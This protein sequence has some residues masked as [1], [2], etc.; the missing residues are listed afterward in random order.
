MF[1]VRSISS[2]PNSS[3]AREAVCLGLNPSSKR[4]ENC[5]YTHIYKHVHIHIY[6]NTC[7]VSLERHVKN[8]FHWFVSREGV[9]VERTFKYISFCTF[10]LFEFMDNSFLFFF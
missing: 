7:I 2:A 5:T 6:A 10:A 3:V 1:V 4:G 8:L 9:W